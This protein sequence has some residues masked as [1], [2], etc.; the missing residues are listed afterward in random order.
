MADCPFG[1][2]VL[3]VHDDDELTLGVVDDVEREDEELLP[4]DEDE[5]D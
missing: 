5:Q 1:G 3:D 4:P 2:I